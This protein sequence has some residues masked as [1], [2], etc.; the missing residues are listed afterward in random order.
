ML[1]PIKSNISQKL[2]DK[3]YR[4]RFFKGRTEDQI[5][6]ELRR[7]RKKRG[8]KQSE[9]A[10]LC[11]MKQSAISR[12]EQASYSKWSFTTLWRI[13][14]ALDIRVRISIDEM[15][16]AIKE[17]EVL[18]KNVCP[19]EYGNVATNDQATIQDHTINMGFLNGT[20]ISTVNVAASVVSGSFTL[21]EV[22]YG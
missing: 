17:Y 12:I 6:Y 14:D 16:D 5:A 2:T 8:L 4:H 3:G 11:G 7:F 9:L 15:A 18:E 20:S 13:S 1:S 22:S 10:A 21:P 19:F